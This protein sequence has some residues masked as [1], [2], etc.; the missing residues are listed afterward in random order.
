M[1]VSINLK[2]RGG[3]KPFFQIDPIQEQ[4][5]V[6]IVIYCYRYCEVIAHDLYL[7]SLLRKVSYSEE[8]DERR[9]LPL[10]KNVTTQVE[11]PLKKNV[12][13]QGVHACSHL[14][15]TKIKGGLHDKPLQLGIQLKQLP[16]DMLKEASIV[17][18]AF[19]E[20]TEVIFW[21]V[22]F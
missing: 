7:T 4:I 15:H 10:K 1:Y 13:S 20:K 22:K 12:T 9:E 14:R 18:Q 11:L 21:P 19:S 8:G 2:N 5:Y 17:P 3:P 6:D 16:C